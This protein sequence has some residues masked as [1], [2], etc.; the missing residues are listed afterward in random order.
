MVRPAL[1]DKDF[2]GLYHLDQLPHLVPE[3]LLEE[4]FP[5]F[6]AAPDPF[7]EV[8]QNPR[9]ELA[10]PGAKGRLEWSPAYPPTACDIRPHDELEQEA[11]QAETPTQQQRTRQRQQQRQRT[12]CNNSAAAIAATTNEQTTAHTDV[13]YILSVRV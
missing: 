2:A 5:A 11:A 1:S 12:R 7:G 6:T 3:P 9:E 13:S 8:D 10:D 4:R